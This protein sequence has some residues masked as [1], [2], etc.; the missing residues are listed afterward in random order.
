MKKQT[1][2]F[3]K[4]TPFYDVYMWLCYQEGKR[5][6]IF[7]TKRKFRS[8]YREKLDLNHPQTFPEKINWL[9]LF[10]YPNAPLAI[11]AGDKWG[12]QTFLKERGL[13]QLAAPILHAYDAVEEIKWE[14]LPKKFVIKKSNASSFNLI[15]TNKA[16]TDEKKVKKR[17]AKW[18]R[19]P[20]GYMTGEYHYE[21]MHPK[22][23]IEA[24]I[25]NIGN[26]WRVFC[27]NGKPELVQVL[28][29]EGDYDTRAKVGYMGHVD[30]GYTHID[31]EGK[32]L[33]LHHRDATSIRIGDTFELP[34][35][36][37]EM[38]EFAKILAKD[39]PF[40]RVDFFHADG[41][42]ILGE[43]TFTPGNGFSVFGEATYGRL[44][45][46]LI[47]PTTGDVNMNKEAMNK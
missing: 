19:L 13:S 8:R 22:I 41:K 12:L 39:F 15:I 2:Q 9:K 18:M 10:Y 44:S 4:R 29:I 3:L 45:D 24:F 46:K 32:I 30:P 6:P 34:P 11:Q 40:V 21:K 7:K 35:D 25:E 16:Q 26:E 47:L 23:I 28:H 14:A 43:L 38:I 27:V 42:L 5:F 20:F 17:V 36:F 37:S 1:R 31:L 33:E